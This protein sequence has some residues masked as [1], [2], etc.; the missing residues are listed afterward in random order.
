M[1]GQ[2]VGALQILP[3]GLLHNDAVPAPAGAQSCV[4]PAPSVGSRGQNLPIPNNLSS[5]GAP[6]LVG[7]NRR[8]GQ[9]YLWVL[10]WQKV[11]FLV[12]PR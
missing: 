12:N 11:P 1:V 4:T 10:K 8:R 5:R 3:E 9:L 2:A 6:E 7:E